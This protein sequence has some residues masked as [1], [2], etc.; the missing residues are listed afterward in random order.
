MLKKLLNKEEHSKIGLPLTGAGS[1]QA[2]VA[3]SPACHRRKNSKR[4]QAT[5]EYVLMVL[6]I[7]SVLLVMFFYSKR[8]L[9]NVI[10]ASADQVGSQSD[11][12]PEAGSV[13]LT[14]SSRLDEVDN[15]KRDVQARGEDR[16]YN[17]SSSALSTGNVISITQQY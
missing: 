9:Q 14:A 7:L 16:Y 13:N 1:L 12:Q 5:V 6:A 11:F 4:G 3:G 17:Y 8:G 10:K 2:S 15:D